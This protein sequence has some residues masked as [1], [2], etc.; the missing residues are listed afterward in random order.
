MI[1]ILGHKNYSAESLNKYKL[2]DFIDDAVDKIDNVSKNYNQ[3]HLIGNSFGAN[4]ACNIALKIEKAVSLVLI[5][6]YA[7]PIFKWRFLFA[8]FGTW[9]PNIK[10]TVK[11][12]IPKDLPVKNQNIYELPLKALMQVEKSRKHLP[13]VLAQIN[14]P[15]LVI[16]NKNDFVFEKTN[17]EKVYRCLTIP[18]KGLFEVKLVQGHFIVNEK[19]VQARIKEFLNIFKS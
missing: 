9:L 12:Y 10:S 11:K 18:D 2:E 7:Y 16:N 19:D 1:S 8:I 13:K 14:I 4:I 5:S 6:P 15:T 17:G 3:I